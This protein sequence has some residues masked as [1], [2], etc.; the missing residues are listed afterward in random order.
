MI[1]GMWRVQRSPTLLFTYPILLLYS[2]YNSWDLIIYIYDFKYQILR[3]LKVYIIWFWF[4]LNFIFLYDENRWLDKWGT[5]N[6][7]WGKT[8]P[9]LA[10]LN[11][12]RGGFVECF[13]YRVG[14]LEDL[15]V[16]NPSCCHPSIQSFNVLNSSL[17]ETCM[18]IVN[19]TDTIRHDIV[20]IS[21]NLYIIYNHEASRFFFLTRVNSQLWN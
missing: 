10:N 1:T 6:P 11:G 18:L 21:F 2:R 15:P 9:I 16:P 20:D 3:Y 7:W 8:L 5:P 13:I 14:W 19:W 12:V 17:H 4:I